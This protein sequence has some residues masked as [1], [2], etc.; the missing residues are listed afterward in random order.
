MDLSLL[1]SILDELDS[2]DAFQ[3]DS[4]EDA[5]CGV[6]CADPKGPYVDSL[7]ARIQQRPEEVR[8]NPQVLIRAVHYNVDTKVIQALVE[9]C[10]DSLSTQNDD[11]LCPLSWL[12]DMIKPTTDAFL[13]DQVQRR[14][15]PGSSNRLNPLLMQDI[16]GCTP[17]MRCCQT[18]T[19]YREVVKR[20]LA[21]CPEAVN[22]TSNNGETPLVADAFK[23]APRPSCCLIVSVIESHSLYWLGLY[24]FETMTSCFRHVVDS[25]L[26]VPLLL[27]NVVKMTLFTGIFIGSIASGE[28]WY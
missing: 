9:A 20:V 5:V 3:K 7:V 10:P 6:V 8:S 17:L 1:D 19:T 12:G 2:Q 23:I 21:V 14:F 26:T 18:R 16:T 28:Q 11:G 13:L 24:E 15:P 25:G 22:I 27:V 4:I